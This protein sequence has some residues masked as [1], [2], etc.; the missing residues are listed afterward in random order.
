MKNF[1]IFL[2]LILGTILFYALC[3]NK[4]SAQSSVEELE[5]QIN[6]LEDKIKEKQGE[7]KNLKNEIAY[8]DTQITYTELKIRETTLLIV[9]REAEIVSLEEDIVNLEGKIEKLE[10]ATGD[11]QTIF[12]AHLREKYKNE[13]GFNSSSLVYLLGSKTLDDLITKLKYLSLLEKQDKT[14]LS[15]MSLMK[16]SFSG[17]KNLLSN[18]KDKIGLLKA[19]IEKQKQNNVSY[20]TRLEDQKLTKSW[21]LQETQNEEAKYQQLL[22]QIRAELESINSAF[23]S[24]IGKEGTE[25]KKGDIVAYEGN[26]G[27]STGPHLHF[28]VYKDGVAVNPR[29][30]LDDDLDWPINDPI[31]TQEYGENYSWYMNNF[32]IPGHNG[33]D[34]TGPAPFYGTPIRAAEDGVAY[35]SYDSKACYMT[36]TVGKGIVIVHD[37]GL[38]TIYWH[39]R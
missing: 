36:G 29:K 33:M 8:T 4:V 5:E 26:T 37:N 7:E 22:A 21:I 27:C 9:K 28:G 38:K 24:I 39:V 35:T 6:E 2:L 12:K 10:L 30:Y 15:Q 32:G 11:Q 3:F 13:E 18:K 34:L 20:K 16:S 31:I 25:V 1:L 14:I 17:Q 19:E 23:A